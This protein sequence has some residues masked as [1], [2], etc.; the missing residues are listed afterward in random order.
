M[1]RFFELHFM[2]DKDTEE[3]LE[4]LKRRLGKNRSQVIR[5]AIRVYHDLVA[6]EKGKTFKLRIVWNL[7]A[8]MKTLAEVARVL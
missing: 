3:K 6:A 5:E 7:P 1:G 8:D 2:C 4:E